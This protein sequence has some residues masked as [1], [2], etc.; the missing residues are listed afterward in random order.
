[1]SEEQPEQL[2]L[3]LNTEKTQRTENKTRSEK[4]SANATSKSARPPAP[5]LNEK[6]PAPTTEG[7]N[8]MPETTKPADFETMLNE[9]EKVV[10]Q[11]EGELKLEEAMAL[12]ERGL[13]LSRECESFLKTAQHRI[14]ILKKGPA[15]AVGTQPFEEE[16]VA[17]VAT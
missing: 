9:L 3:L 12:F 6:T 17:E 14:E 8:N 5:L 16:A 15:G 11:L 13:G 4:S 2:R 1:M 7:P 10:A